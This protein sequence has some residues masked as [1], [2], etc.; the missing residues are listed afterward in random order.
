MTA[1]DQAQPASSRATA[2]FA[3]TG[4]FRRAVKVSHRWCSR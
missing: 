3:T 2:T 4:F 1:S